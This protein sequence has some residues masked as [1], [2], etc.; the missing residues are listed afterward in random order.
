MTPVSPAACTC[1]LRGG[2]H[3][4]LVDLLSFAPQ[5]SRTCAWSTAK[6]PAT[7][8]TATDVAACLVVD[9]ALRWRLVSAPKILQSWADAVNGGYKLTGADLETV[10][11]FVDDAFGLPLK[12]RNEEH[13]RGWL[14]EFL[15]YSLA[16]RVG[17]TSKRRLLHVE[18][19][20]W[21]ATKP[22]RDSITVWERDDGTTEFRLWESKQHT[23]AGS[24]V[25]N[26]VSQATSQLKMHAMRYLAQA[27]SVAAA[28]GAESGLAV[29]EMYADLPR[30]WVT[31]SPRGGIGI[32]VT[33]ADSQVPIRC[34]SRVHKS[35]PHLT[36]ASQIE[37]LVAGIADFAAFTDVVRDRVWTPL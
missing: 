37:G 3:S 1:H 21:H 11:A 18:G 30:L 29:R 35:F 28:A 19:P 22:G 27:T 6:L 32:S 7:H 2:M 26:S 17:T 9:A 23:G 34:F 8:V 24:P 10:E 15:L 25:S 14:A 4:A 13:R 20:D 31:H 12:P 36:Q 16:E 33:T 5:S